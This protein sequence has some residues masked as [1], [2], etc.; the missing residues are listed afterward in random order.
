MIPSNRRR[1][2]LICALLSALTLLAYWPVL[3]NDFINLDDYTYITKNPHVQGGLTWENVKWSFQAGYSGN[4]HPL[5]WLSHMLDVQLFGLDPRWHHLVNLLF[6]IANTLLL[7]LVVP[8][9]DA[10]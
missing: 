2:F 9:P 3:N 5:T 1:S 6:H 7:F 10:A 4:W 8:G